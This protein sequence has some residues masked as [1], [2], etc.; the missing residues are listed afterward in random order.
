MSIGQKDYN[1]RLR[2]A[3]INAAVHHIDGLLQ[4][5]IYVC[6]APTIDGVDLLLYQSEVVSQGL[7]EV[8]VLVPANHSCSVHGRIEFTREVLCCF[9]AKFFSIVPP[10]AF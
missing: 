5:Y 4:T 3:W 10:H 2:C 7:A 1:L 8:D 6:V 9:Q